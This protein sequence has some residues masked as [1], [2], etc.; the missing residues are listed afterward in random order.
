MAA[1]A[2]QQADQVDLDV[3]NTAVRNRYLCWL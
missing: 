1:G 3:G 2:R